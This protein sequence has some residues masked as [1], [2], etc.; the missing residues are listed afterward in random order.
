[1]QPLLQYNKKAAAPKN[2]TAALL[3]LWHHDAYALYRQ[4]HD[5]I[6]TSLL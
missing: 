1:M 3:S 5:T 4:R 2:G 6:V